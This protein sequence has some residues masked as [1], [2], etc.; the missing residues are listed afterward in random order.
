MPPVAYS[1]IRWSDPTQRKG[2]SQERQDDFAGRRERLLSFLI[3]FF[4]FFEKSA[5]GLARKRV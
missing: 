5:S 2:H 3:P 4:A 1:L